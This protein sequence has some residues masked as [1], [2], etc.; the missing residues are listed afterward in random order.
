MN[1]EYIDFCNYIKP[2]VTGCSGYIR[3]NGYMM[4]KPGSLVLL[5]S[6]ETTIAIVP[7]GVIFNIKYTCHIGDFLK[8]KTD[9]EMSN[10]QELC[11]FLG[12]NTI[13]DRIDKYFS[14]YMNLIKYGLLEYEYNNCLELPT[15][16]LNVASSEIHYINI[17]N[18]NSFY[19]IPVS[20]AIT[21]LN[22][23]DTCDLKV[24]KYVMD[25]TNDRI[26]TIR[27]SVYKKKFK[28]SFDVYMNVLVL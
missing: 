23:S 26:K 16:S 21:P 2:I 22:K 6:D 24:Y 3:T 1:Q 10:F 14:I 12:W 18:G 7:L 4:H 17:P 15:F 20:K 28:L 19:R 11:Y 25:P 13:E 5:S 27:Y 8:L 9:E